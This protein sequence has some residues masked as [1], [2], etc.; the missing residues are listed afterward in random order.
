MGGPNRQI[1]STTIT[2][3]TQKRKTETQ[4][5][6]TKNVFHILDDPSKYSYPQ[7]AQ[8]NGNNKETSGI[9]MLTCVNPFKQKHFPSFFLEPEKIFFLPKRIPPSPVVSFSRFFFLFPPFFLQ[10]SPTLCLLSNLLT[11]KKIKYN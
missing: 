4:Q 7:G 11:L 1:F 8:Q 3:Y 2:Q 6:T 9:S 5:V 10:P